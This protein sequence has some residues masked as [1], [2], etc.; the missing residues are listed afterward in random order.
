MDQSSSSK[1]SGNEEEIFRNFDAEVE[2]IIKSDTLPQKSVD[3]YILV[4]DTYIKWKTEHKNS[5]S[6]SEESKLIVYFKDLIKRLK[7]TTVW[8]IWS[9]LKTTFN[10][11]ENIDISKFQNLKSIVRKNSKGYKP[12]KSLIFSWQD[13]TRF[14]NEAPNFVY[15]ASKV[16][17]QIY[18]F[19]SNRI[20]FFIVMVIN[21][22]GTSNLWCLWSDAVR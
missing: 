18:L 21:I 5:L 7:P 9:M 10:S 2:S 4:F 15:L 20:L 19:L 17:I 22:L 8:S 3:R 11:R 12:K 16:S 6:N 13:I 14:I 1:E